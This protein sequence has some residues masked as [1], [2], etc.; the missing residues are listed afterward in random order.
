MILLN[1]ILVGDKVG[2]IYLVKQ[3]MCLVTGYL[4]LVINENLSSVTLKAHL[5]IGLI[6]IS[7][8][9]GI[10]EKSHGRLDVH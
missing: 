5:F 1:A 2:A 4:C 9:L 8:Q 6:N 10:K 7:N 3:E